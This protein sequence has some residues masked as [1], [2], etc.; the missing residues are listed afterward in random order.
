MKEVNKEATE[1]H[2]GCIRGLSFRKLLL[3]NYH[4]FIYKK[5]STKYQDPVSLKVD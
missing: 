4:I 3:L 2:W 1:A 5:E